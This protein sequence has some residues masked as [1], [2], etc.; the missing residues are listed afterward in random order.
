MRARYASDLAA[1]EIL[2]PPCSALHPLDRDV[3]GFSTPGLAAAHHGLRV[4]RLAWMAELAFSPAPRDVGRP[5]RQEEEVP[6]WEEDGYVEMAGEGEL[7]HRSEMVT[8]PLE[9][10]ASAPSAPSAPRRNSMPG[11]TVA[12]RPSAASDKAR[13]SPSSPSS[14]PDSKS[15]D[16]SLTSSFDVLELKARE[17]AESELR[18]EQREQW[19]QV[20]RFHPAAAAAV[21]SG[22]SRERM[23][24]ETLLVSLRRFRGTSL[25]AWRCDFDKQ[26][27]GWVSQAEF[28][29][30]C[31]FYGCSA[32]QIWQSCRVSGGALRLRK[33]VKSQKHI[34]LAR[35]S[36]WPSRT[37]A[38]PLSSLESPLSNAR[39]SRHWQQRRDRNRPRFSRR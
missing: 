4:V 39:T 6:F 34:A 24:V 11:L 2:P 27:V 18:H 38:A 26:G 22:A 15:L 29:R 28:A 17:R 1:A 37:R 8:G 35:S 23:L 7:R 10:Q 9:P 3:S 33:R 36:W 31:R 25:K 5:G 20:P 14:P 16:S 21:S 32:E 13:P 12:R 19:L 30:A